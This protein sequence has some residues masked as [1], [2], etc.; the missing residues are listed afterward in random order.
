MAKIGD[1]HIAE[2]I[3]QDTFLQAYRKLASL[4]NPDRFPGWLYVIAARLCETWFRKKRPNIQSLEATSIDVL[5]KTAYSAYIC[6]Q[7]EA[8]AVEHQRKVVQKLLEKLPESERTVMVLY[9]LGEMSC[10]AIGKFLGVS[11]NTVKS[12]AATGAKT[13]KKRGIYNSRDFWQCFLTSESNRKYYAKQGY[14]S[15][16]KQ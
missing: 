6:E 8:A 10:E 1:F 15:W 3:T 13:I 5:E 11:P 14:D 9:Y 16:E 2:E 4:K 12:Q 7:R